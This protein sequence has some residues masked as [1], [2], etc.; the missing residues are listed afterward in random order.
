MKNSDKAN[1]IEKQF[2]Q[3]RYRI[4]CQK[5][6]TFNEITEKYMYSNHGEFN[7]NVVVL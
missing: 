3:L 7:L 6:T 1:D 5:K 2:E 4:N